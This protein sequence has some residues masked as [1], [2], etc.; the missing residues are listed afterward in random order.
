M[1]EYITRGVH[2]EFEKRMEAEH[3]R[4]NK[5]I[6]ELEE[7]TKQNNKLLVSVEKLA[8][9]MEQMQKEQTDQ[10]KRLEILESR[11]G[12]KWREVSKY[13]LTAIISLALGYIANAIF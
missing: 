12:Q 8:V 3:H 10:G 13:V 11:D 5:R 4:Q 7:S 1:D 9:S 6:S 2:E